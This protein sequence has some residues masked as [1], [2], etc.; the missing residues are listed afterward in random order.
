LSEAI[1]DDSRCI[2]A[3]PGAPCQL[4]LSAAQ[5][6]GTPLGA[7]LA[8]T[9]PGVQRVG[10]LHALHTFLVLIHLTREAGTEGHW[11]GQGGK[12][13]GESPRGCCLHSEGAVGSWMPEESEGGERA[14]PFARS[15]PG[16]PTNRESDVIRLYCALRL[17]VSHDKL[18]VLIEY[19]D[20]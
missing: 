2:R 4:D 16:I 18:F 1:I 12:G 13:Q 6:H 5:A 17:R 20:H 3:P 11:Q 14:I 10:A 9:L 7:R 8:Q 19:S 15:D